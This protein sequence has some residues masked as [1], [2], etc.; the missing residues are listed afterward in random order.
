MKASIRTP[1]RSITSMIFVMFVALAGAAASG[2]AVA[3]PYGQVLAKK[4]TYYG[5]LNLE[6]EAGAKFLYARL[7]RAAQDVCSP[8]QSDE[9]ARKRVW[10]TCVERSLSDAVGRI[11]KPLVTALHNK[12]ASRASTG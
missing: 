7:R 4:V 6:T 1:S 9:L 5:D 11:N 12:S 8:Y 3:Q 10:Q 2:R